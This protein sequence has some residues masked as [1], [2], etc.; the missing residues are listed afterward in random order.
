MYRSYKRGG[1]GVGFTN[2]TAQ[3]YPEKEQE[4][5][6]I[7]PGTPSENTVD[8]LL[9]KLENAQKRM[10]KA[11]EKAGKNVPLS[12][13]C[14]TDLYSVSDAVLRVE[15]MIRREFARR[16]GPAVGYTFSH[17]PI[18][19][20]ADICCIT[21]PKHAVLSVALPVILPGEKS[22]WYSAGRLKASPSALLMRRELGN[23]VMD[24]LLA[25]IHV[26]GAFDVPD[27]RCFLVFRRHISDRPDTLRSTYVDNN[28][29]E[30]GEVTNAICRVVGKGDGYRDMGFLYLSVTDKN[31]TFVEAILCKEMDLAYWI[32][33]R[34]E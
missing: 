2:E 22:E 16:A 25:D 12:D 4:T 14:E 8:D 6:P 20:P 29:I 19:I 9:R 5:E 31:R 3:Q 10:R 15:G 26:N 1:F 32:P 28:N 30:T 17:C 23:L 11:R 24:A 13:I 21:R 18:R 7:L 33:C 34:K 27:E